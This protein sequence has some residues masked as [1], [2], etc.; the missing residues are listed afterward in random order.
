MFNKILVHSREH[1]C[2]TCFSLTKH[3]KQSNYQNHFQSCISRT[4]YFLRSR[5]HCSSL[6]PRFS[7]YFNETLYILS[8]LFENPISVCFVWVLCSSKVYFLSLHF[9]STAVPD[10]SLTLIEIY[11]LSFTRNRDSYL[12]SSSLLFQHVFRISSQLISL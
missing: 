9:I 12:L 2:I 11:F 1:C 10:D 3:K 5:K 7:C 4:P 8:T 6:P